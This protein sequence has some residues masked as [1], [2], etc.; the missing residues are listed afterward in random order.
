[1]PLLIENLIATVVW[2]II[3]GLTLTAGFVLVTIQRRVTRR[4]YFQ[5]LDRARQRAQDLVEPLYEGGGDLDSAIPAF[6]TFRS[7]VERRALESVVLFHTRVSEHMNTTREIAQRMGWIREWVDLVRARLKPPTGAVAR[8]L[9]E[10]GDNYTP[11][12]QRLRLRLRANFVQ[13]CL[14]ADKL[15]RVPTPEGLLALLAA[16]Q[17]PHLDVEEVCIR[18]LGRM[19][20]PATLPVL[21]ENLID[22]LEGR[23]RQ[24]IRNLKTSLVL[25]PLEE[26]DAFRPALEHANRRIRFFATDIIREIADRQAATELLSKNDFSPEMYRLFSE[27]LCRDEWGDVRARAAVVIGH[28]HDDMANNILQ[29]LLQDE[30]WYVRLHACRAAAGKFFLPVASSVAERVTDQHW[31]VREAAVRSLRNMGDFGIEQIYRTFLASEDR[32]AAEQIA[33]EIQRSGMLAELLANI[34]SEEQRRQAMLVCRRMVAIGRVTMLLAYLM[35]PVH[36]SLK[37]LL[38]RELSACTT[39][40]CLETLR[41]CA[42]EDADAQVRTTA[43]SAFQTG[44]THVTAALGGNQ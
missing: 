4:R 20:D 42:D 7:T 15:V 27:K 10:L 26:I 5:Q 36:P 38:I 31:L 12:K 17:D 43:L 24:S 37:L 30:A 1:M 29:K 3:V 9:A 13:R 32:Y 16:T 28:F 2:L 14:A 35:S 33:E 25:F 6:R 19:A 41:R 23:S 18:N 8:V 21:I 39:P 11:P 40:E 34:E 44:V 22:V